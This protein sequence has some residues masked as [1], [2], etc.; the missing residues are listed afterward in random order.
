MHT[1]HGFILQCT[2]VLGSMHTSY[3][4]TVVCIPYSTVELLLHLEYAYGSILRLASAVIK[5]H[6]KKGPDHLFFR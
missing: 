6:Q 1:H 4:F 3:T 2:R 5:G